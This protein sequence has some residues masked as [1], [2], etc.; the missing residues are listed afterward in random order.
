MTAANLCLEA[1]VLNAHGE[2]NILNLNYINSFIFYYSN[3]RL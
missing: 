1:V 2:V 3:N